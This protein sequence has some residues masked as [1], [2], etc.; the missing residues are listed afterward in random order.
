MITYPVLLEC[1]LS[2]I[3]VFAKF[4]LGLVQVGATLRL[5]WQKAASKNSET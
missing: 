2:I 3:N 4:F 5:I 1:K